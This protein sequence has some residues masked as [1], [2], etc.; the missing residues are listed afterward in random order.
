VV[1]S[2]EADGRLVLD[3]VELEEPVYDQYQVIPD[4]FSEVGPARP[5]RFVIDAT[6]WE[7]VE[8]RVIESTLA[9]DF[10]SIDQRGLRRSCDHFWQLAISRTGHPGRKFFDRLEHVD[11]ARGEI[12]DTWQAPPGCY[13]GNEPIFLGA[14]GDE[15][16]GVVLCKLFDAGRRHD[17]FLLFDAFDVAAG[18]VARL[19][20]EEPTPPGFHASFHPALLG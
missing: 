13:L 10:P 16:A 5:T 14:P 1:N 9:S 7:I 8:K 19:H 4:L 18:P 15:S 17:T 3:V 2:F 20:L 6:S 12:A 11:L